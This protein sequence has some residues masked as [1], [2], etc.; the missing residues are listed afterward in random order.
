MD[1]SLKKIVNLLFHKLTRNSSFDHIIHSDLKTHFDQTEGMINFE[2]ATLLYDMAKACRE[3]CIL[4]VG[5]YRGRSAVALGRGSIDGHK[6]PVYAI[7]PHEEFTGELGG[8][9]GPPDRAAFYTAMLATSC[10]HVVRL[11]NLSSEMVAPGWKQK[12]GLLF[13]DGDHSYEGVKRDFECWSP[14]LASEALIA[15]DDSTNPELGPRRLID[16][17]TNS[18][19][20]EEINRVRN[21]TV[22]AR[23]KG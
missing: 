9:F 8:K 14:H 19:R 3:G 5:S 12:I 18:G 22:I 16:E 15:F 1:K 21:V 13:I 2:E 7:E 17:L 6:V 4:E 10:Y 11:V 20:F 23:K